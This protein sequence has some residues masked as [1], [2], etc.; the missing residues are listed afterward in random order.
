EN[1]ELNLSDEFQ[2]W[3]SAIMK[4]MKHYLQ[5]LPI[6]NANDRKKVQLN[7][8]IL[9]SEEFLELWDKIKYKTVYSVKFDS[10]Q[11]IKK[12]IESIQKMPPIHK[13]RILS[14]KDQVTM[15]KVEGIH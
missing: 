2:P 5:R 10:E 11:L 9:D 13:I 8:A 15:D 6:K 1:Y 4:E 12:S 7:K 14:R 3:K